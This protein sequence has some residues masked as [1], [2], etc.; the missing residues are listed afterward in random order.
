MRPSSIFLSL[1]P[2]PCSALHGASALAPMRTSI[3]TTID[4]T[5]TQLPAAS[6]STSITSRRIS[7]TVRANNSTNAD[8]AGCSGVMTHRAVTS[9]YTQA[10]ARRTPTITIGS[11]GLARRSELL[12]G[13]K[14]K[15]GTWPNMRSCP[16]RSIA[17]KKGGALKVLALLLVLSPPTIGPSFLCWLGEGDVCQPIQRGDSNGSG[18][19]DQTDVMALTIVL[20]EGFPE[21]H[22]CPDTLD[23]DGDGLIGPTDA[24]H[25]V[26][27]LYSSQPHP[28]PGYVM[29]HVTPHSHP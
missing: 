11:A 25:L 9:A 4:S 7:A 1:Q 3:F 21:P 28:E 6:T 2:S 29:C 12:F 24:V 10:A 26:S 18:G 14:T 27:W 5:S 20:S 8:P 22:P 16:L 17:G 15:M 19:L 23:V 13:T